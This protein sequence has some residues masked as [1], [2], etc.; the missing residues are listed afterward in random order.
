M[1]GE[2][3]NLEQN[4]LK[5]PA[6]EGFRDIKPEKGMTMDEADKHWDGEF[7]KAR[8]ESPASSGENVEN[9]EMQGKAQLLE[10]E[11]NKEIDSFQNTDVKQDQLHQEIKEESNWPDKIID[12]IRSFAEYKIYKDAGLKPTVIGD[13][14]ALIRS[15]IDLTLTDE[16]GRTNKERMELGK[17]PLDKNG[18]PI[19]LHHIG[20]HKDSP[21]A[22][23]THEEHRCNGNDSVLHNKN[24]ETEV[25][26]QGNTWE[27]EKKDFWESRINYMEG[28][29]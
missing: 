8:M 3:R 5:A 27:K 24:I 25:H 12:N 10:N 16:Y 23:L 22:E 14:F 2:F 20:Q 21:L 9:T 13:R 15:D 19:E 1:N 11:Q 29:K 18:N 6:S 17:P 28:N 4:E 26:G 7:E